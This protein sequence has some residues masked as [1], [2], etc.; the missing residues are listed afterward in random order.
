MFGKKF[1]KKNGKDAEREQEC[2]FGLKQKVRIKL[3]GIVGVVDCLMV[4]RYGHTS[5]SVEYAMTTT[6]EIRSRWIDEEDLDA[7]TESSE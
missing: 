2:K 1:G 4:N 5:A 7:V 6:G 3:N